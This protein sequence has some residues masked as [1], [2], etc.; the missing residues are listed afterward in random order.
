MARAAV[1]TLLTRV[2]VLHAPV[3]TQLY[4]ASSRSQLGSRPYSATG[5]CQPHPNGVPEGRP[6]WWWWGRQASWNRGH[7]P[8]TG[9][10]AQSVSSYK[11]VCTRLCLLALPLWGQ[12]EQKQLT[13]RSQQD[14][15][16]SRT[17]SVTSYQNVSSLRPSAC[18]QNL[19]GCHCPSAGLLQSR[20]LGLRCPQLAP[21]SSI[22]LPEVWPDPEVHLEARIQVPEA[23][24]TP[25]SHPKRQEGLT[26]HVHLL[27][28]FALN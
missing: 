26:C 14:G 7:H 24:N 17:K 3:F 12:R 5:V 10:V 20:G 23:Q 4:P 22:Q 13:M 1:S 11:L 21:H 15:S 16:P 9:R 27:Q 19:G 18:A 8:A 6:K 28:S 25:H 2:P